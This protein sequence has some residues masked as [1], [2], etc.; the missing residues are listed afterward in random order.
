MSEIKNKTVLVIGNG[1]DIAN[2]YKTKYS[3]F[4]YFVKTQFDKTNKPIECEETFIS[5]AKNNN[6]IKHFLAYERQLETWVDV[7]KEMN[8]IVNA[9]KNIYN[10]DS[11]H[12]TIDK[13]NPNIVRIIDYTEYE[14]I[15][16]TEF[17]FITNSNPNGFQIPNKRFYS[18][19][20]GINWDELNNELDNQ[21]LGLKKLLTSYLRD[22]MP[23]LGGGR[24]ILM[25]L[26]NIN[27][28]LIIT[29]NYTDFYKTYY[30]T[31]DVYHV[32]GSIKDDNIILGY[33]DD[34][35]KEVKYIKF[36]KYFQK[37]QNKIPNINLH[38]YYSTDQI[39]QWFKFKSLFYGLSLDKTDS[40][41]IIKIYNNSSEI[42]IYYLNQ[43]DYENK[44]TN[45]IEI[46]GK[47]EVLKA[48]NSG[49]IKFVEIKNN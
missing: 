29:F 22:Y 20:Y 25:Q 12:F 34:N 8:R 45:L 6:F 27:P 47:D 31:D 41:E 15:V 2:G 36:K 11:R 44:M 23:K 32:H 19:S 26:D 21:L 18:K 38:D 13:T 46:I 10:E 49:K 5:E 28:N 9:I 39:G 30:D 1:F 7:E 48:Y 16:L 37:I 24:N 3:D 40:E 35:P 43:R 42:S 4:L 33:E 17:S 14:R